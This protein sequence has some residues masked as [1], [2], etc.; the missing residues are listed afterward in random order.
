[1]NSNNLIRITNKI[2]KLEYIISHLKKQGTFKGNHLQVISKTI[3][4]KDKK[5]PPN[6]FSN[7]DIPLTKRATIKAL[8]A[9]IEACKEDI[10]EYL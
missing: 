7:W 6:M 2:K 4:D 10:K 5:V 8:E 1:M 9:E 3:P